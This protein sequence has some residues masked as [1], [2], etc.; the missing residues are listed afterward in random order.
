LVRTTSYGLPSHLHDHIDLIQPTTMFGTFKQYK[1]T[2][3]KVGADAVIAQ[4][5]PN[6]PAVKA[7]SGITVDASCNKTIT[8]SCL[9]QLYNAVGVV[10]SATINNSIAVTAYLVRILLSNYL[11]LG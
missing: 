1:S 3:F 8:I 4:P 2:A 11:D 9:Q 5:D 7:G 10:P 6:V